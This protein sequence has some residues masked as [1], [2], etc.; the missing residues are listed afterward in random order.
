MAYTTI[1]QFKHDNGE[2]VISQGNFQPGSTLF[3]QAD[4]DLVNNQTNCV[5]MATYHVTFERYDDSNGG[6]I[7]ITVM[8]GVDG[9]GK[10]MLDDNS[11]SALPWPPYYHDDD[12]AY[13]PGSYLLSG[14]FQSS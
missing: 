3:Y 4:L 14:N 12:D 13:A 8:V 7:H 9:N 1:D 2:V 10:Y 5:S 11:K 6:V